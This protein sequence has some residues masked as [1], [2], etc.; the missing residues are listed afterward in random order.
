MLDIKFFSIIDFL[1]FL[2]VN[3][4]KMVIILRDLV[5]EQIPDIKE[6]FSYNVPYFKK[7]SNICFI[8]PSSIMWGNKKTYDGV[9]FG[10][11]KGYLIN[12]KISYLDKG[13]R[14]FV[15]WKD[16]TKITQNDLKI[17][18]KYLKEAV[19]IDSK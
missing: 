8:W 4:R 7:K 13:T 18:S 5:Y 19:I 15:Y 3:E 12:D 10:F 1:E 6:K 17:L 16:F 14:K 9:R 2:P 11:T